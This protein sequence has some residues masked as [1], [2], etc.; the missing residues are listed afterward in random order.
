M[1]TVSRTTLALVVNLLLFSALSPAQTGKSTVVSK[2]NQEH[3]SRLAKA[4]FWRH[5]KDSDKKAQ[6]NQVQHATSKPAQAK[7]Q[8]NGQLKPVSAKQATAK[9]QPQHADNKPL[10]KKAELAN[11]TKPQHKAQTKPVS[12]KQTKP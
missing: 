9:N 7:A 11:K 2:D 1:S 5:H 3:H 10:A 12:L 6:S 8:A 4:A